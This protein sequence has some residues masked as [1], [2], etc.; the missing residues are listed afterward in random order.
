MG[1]YAATRAWVL[2]SVLAL[3]LG[4]TGQ[5]AM[6]APSLV[7]LEDNDNSN[8]VYQDVIES[9]GA[10]IVANNLGRFYDHIDVLTG[11]RATRAALFAQIRKRGQKN[12]VD[13]VLLTHGDDKRLDLRRGNITE[14]DIRSE[15][16]LPKLRMVYMLACNGASLLDAWHSVG[17]QVAIGHQDTNSL[18]GFFFPHFLR[19]WAEGMSARDAAADAYQFAEGTAQTL[20][21]Y[22]RESDLLN[23]VGIQRSVPVLA[24]VDTDR[25]GRVFPDRSLAISTLTDS[26]LFVS[27]ASRAS[28]PHSDFE[29]LGIA[30]LGGMLPQATLNAEAIPSPQ[31]LLE[32]IKEAAWGQFRDSFPQP[33]GSFPE[34]TMP[35]F[36]LPTEVGQ[37][38]WIDG[39]AL[40]Y[41]AAPLRQ[42]GGPSF[43]QAL[44][45][46]QGARLSRAVDRLNVSIY[47]T[48]AFT[49][50]LK[51]RDQASNWQPYAVYVPKAVRFSVAMN[52]GV[53]NIFGLDQGHDALN[54]ELKMPALPEAVYLRSVSANLSDGKVRVEA[55]VIGNLITVIAGAE[56]VA[57]KFTGVDIWATIDSNLSLFAWPTLFFQPL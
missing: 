24:G 47:F 6:A 16:N 55:G 42:F 37:E 38:I 11:E 35:A 8:A 50:P 48:E 15:G 22:I 17:A 51:D 33:Q 46:I 53:L 31:A 23:G 54:L 32:Q 28:Y 19:R 52:D 45:R 41:F 25:T 56:V 40:K 34:L 7:L 2:G 5:A 18:P 44:D 14:A 3:A 12:V 4:L 36:D 9:L 57:R 26:T 27:S 49:L 29:K 21:S 30:L 43:E 39:E 13:V 10:V 1:G 20:S